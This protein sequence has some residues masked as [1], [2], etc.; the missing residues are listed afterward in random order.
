MKKIILV[1]VMAL[2]LSA[3]AQPKTAPED[4]KLKQ[5]YST[6]I[7]SAQGD[8]D[9]V[10]GCQSMLTELAKDRK[11][12]EFAQKEAVST[13]DYQNC[14]QAT[15]TGNDQSVKAKCDKIWQEIRAH[16]Q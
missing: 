8:P 1:T 15:R 3:C 2:G 13:L 5:D 10:Q 6:C 14:I 12:Q 16:N 7:N 4:S 11:H 9:K